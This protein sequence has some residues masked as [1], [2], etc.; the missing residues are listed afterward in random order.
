MEHGIWPR[1]VGVGRGLARGC[2]F[3]AL[4]VTLFL[5]LVGTYRETAGAWSPSQ[6]WPP[7]HDRSRPALPPW[8]EPP[9]EALS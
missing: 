5:I 1:A 8:F 2:A 6:P 9:D 7:A 4:T 3:V